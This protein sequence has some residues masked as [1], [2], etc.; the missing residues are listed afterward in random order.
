MSLFNLGEF[1]LASGIK[2]NF[3]IDCDALTDQDWDAAAALLSAKVGPYGPVYGV[4]S[5]GM[6]LAERLRLSSSPGCFPLIVDDVWTTGGS[7]R[8]TVMELGLGNYRVAVLFGRGPTP[9]WVTAL[10]RMDP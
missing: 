5:G 10:F 6:K 1:R 9:Y 7:V 4:P 2:S 3:K 8:R